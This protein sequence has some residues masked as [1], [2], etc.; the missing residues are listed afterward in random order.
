MQP[1]ASA[2]VGEEHSA[3]RPDPTSAAALASHP[4]CCLNPL[5]P[6]VTPRAFNKEDADAL[7]LLLA[8]H[9]YCYQRKELPRRYIH[10]ASNILL[11][12]AIVSGIIATKHT[13][14]PEWWQQFVKVIPHPRFVK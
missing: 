4:F 8:A 5:Q 3:P 9:C 11:L 14:L 7:V 2:A 1:E 12:D 10:W 13:F 6:G